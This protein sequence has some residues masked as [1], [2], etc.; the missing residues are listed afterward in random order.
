MKKFL[1]ISLTTMLLVNAVATGQCVIDFSQTA[2]GIYPDTL[3]DGTAGVFYDEDITFVMLTDTLGLTI[4]NYQIS[5]ITG[6]PV[7]ITWQC[8]NFQTGCN[9]DPSVSLYGCVKLSGTP[10]VPGSFN[11]TVT[12]IADV[13]LA[14]QQVISFDKPLNILPGT[15]SNPG[16]G[17]TNNVGCAPLTVGFTNNNPGQLTYLWDFG[18]GLQ[19]NLEN[20]PAQTYTVPGTYVVTQTV[21]PNTTPSWY[22]T[23]ITVNSIPNNYGGILDDPDMYFFI[24][25]PQGIEIYDSRP[26]INGTFPPVSWPISNIPLSNGNYTVHVWD[27]DGGLFGADDDLG[28]IT[29]AGNGPSGSATGTVSGASGTLNVNYTIFQTPVLPLVATDTII[30]Y[31]SPVVPAIAASGPLVYCETD[32][33]ILS[34]QDTVNFIQW[35]HDG[36]VLVGETSGSLVPGGSGNYSVTVTSPQGCTAVSL[37]VAVVIHPTPSKPTFFINGNTFTTGVTGLS[38][39]WYYNGSPIPGATGNNFTAT[40]H[41]TYML[42]G[43]DAN[44]CTNCS[45]T[46]AFVNTMAVEQDANRFMI[47]PNPSSNGR[48][49]ILFTDKIQGRVEILILEP[50]GRLV[51]KLTADSQNQILY[52]GN[53]LPGSYLVSINHG[54]YTSFKSLV[55]NGK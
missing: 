44:G 21:T 48:F 46:L 9:Y 18:N 51:D 37:P 35:Y 27:E 26:A 13:Q 34:I 45:D 28:A 8:N 31:A 24:Y 43:T 30:V 36:T 6:L 38:L 19:S 47:Y 55:V 7:G 52:R 14:G 41:G 5:N 1:L 54:G 40:L 29:F 17:M 20:P 39:Q 15:V 22:L 49:T 12:V 16:F 32:S 50:T 25:N 3:P 4:Y 33:V 11:M 2:A 42:C 10:V 23:N 53:L